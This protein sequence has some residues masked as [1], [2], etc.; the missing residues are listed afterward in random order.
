MDGSSRQARAVRAVPLGSLTQA[1]GLRCNG[2]DQRH[3]QLLVE[4]AGSWPPILLWGS[5]NQVVDG[6][7]RVAAAHE[8]GMNS[9]KAEWFGGSAEE[10]FLEGVKRNVTHGLPLT[11]QDRACVVGRVLEQ[12]RQWSDRRIAKLCGVAPTTVARIR[13]GQF[14]PDAVRSEPE[15]RIGCDGRVRP[16]SPANA[17]ERVL[18]AKGKSRSVLTKDRLT[19][20]RISR[21]GSRRPRLTQRDSPPAE[22]LRLYRPRGPSDGSSPASHRSQLGQALAHRQRRR[23]RLEAGYRSVYLRVGGPYARLVIEGICRL[24]VVGVRRRSTTRPDLRGHR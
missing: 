13:R 12:H 6:A 21:D 7:H 1:G 19:R 10:A 14:A 2:L 20:C 22:R 8:L 15:I 11:M 23:S 9:I 5:D 4:S 16:T 17:R 24:P 3:V 18:G